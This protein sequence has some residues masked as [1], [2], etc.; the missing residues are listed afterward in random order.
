MSNPRTI[1][2]DFSLVHPT[3]RPGEWRKT[4]DK[5]IKAA[6]S[7]ADYEYVVCA[8]F[9]D[10]GAITPKDAEP[11]R[12]VWNYG[13]ACSVDATNVAA[14]CAIGRVLVVISDDIYPCDHWDRK[15]KEILPLWGDKECVVRVS[16]GGTADERGL[17]TVQILNRL[18]YERVGYLFHPSYVSMYSDDEFSMHAEADGVV[19]NAPEILFR[20]E[21]WSTGERE[22][23]DVY[24]AQN[25]PKR[26]KFGADLLSYRQAAGFPPLNSEA[27]SERLNVVR[28]VL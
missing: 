10:F 27:L 12:L 14:Q 4:R 3:A 24:R 22:M 1:R 8:D 9:K 7:V 6:S 13:K 23:D 15:L 5:W 2:P 28:Q 17:L 18:R 20:H 19:V 11:A 21:H 25:H 16:T 26:Y